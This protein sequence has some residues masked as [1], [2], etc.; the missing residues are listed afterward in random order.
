MLFSEIFLNYWHN[1]FINRIKIDENYK[2]P[3]AEKRKIMEELKEKPEL[4]DRFS[5]SILEKILKYYQDENERKKQVLKK[6]IV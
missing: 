3:E 4:L 1:E 6:L 2:N 5:V